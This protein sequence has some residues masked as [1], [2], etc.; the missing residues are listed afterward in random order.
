MLEY[1]NHVDLVEF[2]THQNGRYRFVFDGLFNL[3][4]VHF[5]RTNYDLYLSEMFGPTLIDNSI[6]I[7]SY[8]FEVG[9]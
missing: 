2:E 5:H 8:K 9:F 6:N 4:S 7:I 1:A 3:F